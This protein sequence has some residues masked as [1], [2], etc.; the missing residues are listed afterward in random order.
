MRDG[1]RCVTWV[2]WLS[3]LALLGSLT[4]SSEYGRLFDV[5]YCA[6]SV[7]NMIRCMALEPCAHLSGRSECAKEN[8]AQDVIYIWAMDGEGLFPF[9]SVFF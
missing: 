8:H 5:L 9:P 7:G 6:K 4:L 3:L 1:L 2:P